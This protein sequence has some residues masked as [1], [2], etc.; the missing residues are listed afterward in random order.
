MIEQGLGLAS[1]REAWGEIVGGDN[2]G[3]GEF[4]QLL[5]C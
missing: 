1:L 2:G 5:S 3:K 4:G